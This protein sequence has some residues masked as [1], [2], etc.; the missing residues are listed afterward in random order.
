MENSKL[1]SET[2]LMQA[3]IAAIMDKK[4]SESFK[5]TVKG[6]NENHG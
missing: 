3:A 2:L 6:L 4:A 1:L 5:K